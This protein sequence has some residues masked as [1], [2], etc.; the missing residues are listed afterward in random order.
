MNILSDSAEIFLGLGT[1]FDNIPPL[2]LLIL[3][4]L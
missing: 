1:D 2:E 4:R 3:E